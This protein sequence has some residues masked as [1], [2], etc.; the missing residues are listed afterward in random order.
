MESNNLSRKGLT[1]PDLKRFDGNQ[2]KTI[3]AMARRQATLK[4]VASHF[5]ISEK[6]LDVL[7]AEQPEAEEAYTFGKADGQFSLLSRAYRS[8]SPAMQKFLLKNFCGLTD[9]HTVESTTIS[10]TQAVL[11]LE[12]KRTKSLPAPTVTHETIEGEFSELPPMIQDAIIDDA[13]E[14]E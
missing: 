9:K 13:P 7:F 10:F 8:Q 1:G 2:L 4:M 3:E 11:L 12:D 6:R 14:S 5:R